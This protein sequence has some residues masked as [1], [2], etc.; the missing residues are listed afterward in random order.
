MFQAEFSMVKCTTSSA[1]G[2]ANVSV[3]DVREREFCHRQRSSRR[4]KAVA[5]KL[6]I[7]T[8]IIV[9]ALAC[10]AATA[11]PTR[12]R[13]TPQRLADLTGPADAPQGQKF[14]FEISGLK[15]PTRE[16]K[17]A[18]PQSGPG[19]YTV[20]A[21][22][23]AVIEM[24]REFRYPTEFSPPQAGADGKNIVVP[25]TPKAFEV[26][27]TGWT[28]TLNAKAEGKLVALSGVADYAEAELINGGYGAVS[29]PIYT[30]KGEILSPNVVH[31]PKIKTTSTR[32]HIF[33]MPGEPYD[34]TLYRGDK[35][36][37]ITFKLMPE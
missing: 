10:L 26:T 4:I 34:V 20:T 27:N 23:P 28:I 12:K 18:F 21:G 13:L 8:F 29:G 35:A 19:R 15:P 6:P 16:L 2:T 36:E 32:F 30:D 5:M 33:A 24:I 7:R 9:A 31:Q 3:R 37:K 25:M 11:A 22:I 1:A 17:Q 14:T